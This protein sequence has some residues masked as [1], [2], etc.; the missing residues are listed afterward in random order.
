MQK[1]TPRPKRSNPWHRIY[2]TGAAILFVV[3]AFG[4][5]K[6]FN[7]YKVGVSVFV[8]SSLTV[9]ITYIFW[10]KATVKEIIEEKDGFFTIIVNTV[11]LVPL[12]AQFVVF[13]HVESKFDITGSL[14]SKLEAEVRIY[15]RKLA[16][17]C[18]NPISG[19]LRKHVLHTSA[20]LYH[21]SQYWRRFNPQA[22]DKMIL[23]SISAE[24]PAQVDQSWAN[25]PWC[26]VMEECR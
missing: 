24:C 14:Q 7:S 20:N 17:K 16:P 1:D 10:L 26:F 2:F 23:D 13:T 22:A 19:D 5:R 25:D 21:D 4:Y 6:G 12:I 9:L 3:L 18:E 8:I 15:A 11:G